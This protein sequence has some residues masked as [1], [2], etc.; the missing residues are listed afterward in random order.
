MPDRKL[1]AIEVN[2][3]HRAEVTGTVSE[4]RRNEV[5][6]IRRLAAEGLLQIVEDRADKFGLGVIKYRLPEGGVT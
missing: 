6:V 4:V 1:R 3:I 5:N 2:V